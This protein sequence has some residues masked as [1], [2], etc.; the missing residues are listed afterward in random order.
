MVGKKKNPVYRKPWNHL[1]AKQK[2]LRI[3]SLEVLSEARTT[4]QSLTKIAK[5]N[6]ISPR[7]VRHNT[8]AFKKVNKRWVAKRSDKIPRS[9][10]I[11]KNGKKISI[12]VNDSRHASTIGR[13][14][15]VVKEFLSTENKEKLLKFSKKKI[16]D[17]K[18]RVHSFE[19]NSKKLISIEEK[20]EE[21]EFVDVY[22][23]E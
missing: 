2:E 1:N 7:T 11:N 15:N 5:Q 18:G 6:G 23:F 4:K 19:I 14:H 3:R 22:D 8:N 13:Y 17:S 21:P 9:M 20:V 10:I 12:E 16:R